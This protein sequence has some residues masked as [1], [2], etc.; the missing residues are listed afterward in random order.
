MCYALLCILIIFIFF[1]IFLYDILLMCLKTQSIFME[2]SMKK[3]WGDRYDGRRIRKGDPTNIIMPYLMK[4]RSDAQVFFDSEIDLTNVDKIIQEKRKQGLDI[5][6]LDYMLTAIVRTL[7]QFPRI[8][9]FIAGRR[10]YAR[11]EIRISMVVKKEL[12]VNAEET[13]VKFNFK[14]DST[15]YDINSTLR[16]LISENKGKESSNDMDGF[17]GILNHLPRPLFSI[18]INF[19]TWLDFHGKLPKFIHELSPFHT[20]VFLTNMGSIG[21]EPIY[22]HIYSWG[23]TSLFIAMGTKK[24]VRVINKDGKIKEKKVMKLRLVADERIADGYY[25]SKSLKYFTGLFLTPE[26]LETPPEQVV[27]D[28]QI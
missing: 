13:A 27:E 24:M 19:L 21:A 23:T 7:S 5:G 15:I 16:N 28:D 6:I 18:T 10:L 9:R 17:I 25:L 22:H 12:S 20:S 14:P 26:K 11:D 2:K 8:N 3:R 4:E 1:I